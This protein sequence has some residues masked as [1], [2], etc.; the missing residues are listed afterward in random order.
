MGLMA[1]SFLCSSGVP[2]RSSC[3]WVSDEDGDGL[4]GKEA[5]LSSMVAIAPVTWKGYAI[6]MSDVVLVLTMAA[7]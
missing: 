3:R 5:L 7:A 4:G 6:V 1:C 2:Q